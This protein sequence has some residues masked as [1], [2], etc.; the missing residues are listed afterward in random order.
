MVYGGKPSTGCYLCRKR[1]I[2]CDEALPGCRNCS[3]YG[4]PCPGY[5]PDTIFRN[6]NQKVERLMRKRSVTPT[7]AS[8]HSSRSTSVSHSSP[9]L[10]LILSQVAD[11]TWEE[12]AVCHFFDQ[13]TSVSDECLNHLGFLPSLYATCRDSGQDDSVS[14]CLKLATEATALITLSNHMKA[15]PLLLK[16]RG[17]YGLALHGLRRLLGTRSQAVRDETFATMV[18]LSIFEDIAGERNGLHSS[19]TK[20]FGL[21]MGMR[22]ESQLSH[23]QG[24]D[25]F[26]CAYAHTLIESIVLRTRPRHASTELI[27]GQLDGSEPVPRLMLTASKIGQL[28]AESSSHQGSIDIDTISQLT[29]WIETGNIL[30][31]EMAS[32]SQHLPDHWLPLV[33]YTATGGPLMTYQNASIA[34]IWTYYRAARISL[35]RHLL[36][37]RQTLASLVGDNQACDVHRDAALE[38]I[39]EMTTDTCRSIP[40][41]LGDIDALGQTIPTSAEGRPPIRALYGYLML[42]PLW[43]VLTFGMGTAAQMEQIRSALGRVGSVLGIKLAL[44]LAQQGSMSQHATAL[45][46]NPYRFVPSTS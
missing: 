36:D 39:Q 32:W 2:K 37:L 29:T 11:S 12:R 33:V 20:G 8:Q 40:F 26:I 17:Y 43:Y 35:Q 27:V 28:F 44:M 21:L 13:F 42:W 19:H 45:T 5:R 46:P 24:R 22:G 4:R 15:P 14:S 34:A 38:E 6:E 3:V 25:L 9:E 7:T 23:A 41:S 10:P 31:L 30:A 18:I 1:K 16:A